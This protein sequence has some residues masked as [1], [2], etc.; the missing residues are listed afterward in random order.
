MSKIDLDYYE[1]III[2]K[3]LTDES[4]LVS[5]I[6][7]IDCEYFTDDNIKAVINIIQVFYDKHSHAPTVTEI[8]SYLITPELKSKFKVV[9]GYLKE[10]VEPDLNNDELVENTE[11]F[12]REKAVYNTLLSVAKECDGD[13]EI[14]TSAVLD[15]FEKACSIS[16]KTDLGFDVFNQIDKHIEELNERDKTVPTTW[17]WLDDKLEGGL[18]E[19]GRSLYVFAGE[20]NIGKSIILG[21]VA[22]NI[23]KQNKVVLLVTLEMSEK[24]Y[25]KRLTSSIS[26]IPINNLSS[27]S[28]E[29]RGQL[30]GFKQQHT[31]SRLLVKEFPP[32]TITVSHLKNFIQKVVNTGIQLDCIVVD[33]VNLLHDRTGNNS[34]ERIK[35]ATEKLRALSYTFS[36]PI[37]TATQ[38][39]RQGYNESNPSLDTVS[40]SIG[41]AA[42]ADAIFSLW[43][44]EEDAEMGI[45][46]MGVMK[47]RFGPNFGST[48]MQVNYSTLTVTEDETLN[49]DNDST[50]DVTAED[51]MNLLS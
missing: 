14:D 42:T 15:L 12:F 5:V 51:M 34:Y 24:M 3:I 29:L 45:M 22:V 6:D 38:L 26:S 4:Y 30:L 33:Y 31:K 43:Q 32:N 48:A 10:T 21:N 8:K 47:N 1:K 25:T 40:E 2:Y 23:A 35:H 39:N 19:E 16:L 27:R 11:R 37:V 20:T 46:R 17:K 36:C 9:V 44:E 41:L 7:F 49:I 13:D 28:E 18:L 50:H